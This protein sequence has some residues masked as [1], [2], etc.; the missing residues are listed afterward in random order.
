M[1]TS[2][3]AKGFSSLA[4]GAGYHSPC[5]PV[6]LSF[7][8]STLLLRG[9]EFL[10]SLVSLFL[11]R[12]ERWGRWTHSFCKSKAF[13]L[14]ALQNLHVILR[15]MLVYLSCMLYNEFE[16]IF[17]HFEGFS[18]FVI[19]NSLWT[20]I[21]TLCALSRNWWLHCSY[22]GDFGVASSDCVRDWIN[23]TL[24]EFFNIVQL[25]WRLIINYSFKFICYKE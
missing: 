20:S 8:V 13:K 1:S 22:V 19:L 24:D 10:H 16:I 17:A 21:T 14:Y 11:Q 12:C 23:I 7:F 5:L 6:P 2:G 18:P 4:H 9:I 25:Q 15:L 3:S